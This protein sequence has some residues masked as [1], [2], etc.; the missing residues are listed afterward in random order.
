MNNNN[1]SSKRPNSRKIVETTSN[2]LKNNLELFEILND[3]NG[4]AIGYTCTPCNNKKFNSEPSL[5]D[6]INSH[7]SCHYKVWHSFSCNSFIS[8]F[9]SSL[10]LMV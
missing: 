8:F 4:K 2:I 6:H 1:N 10:Y 5:R 3:E 9:I 7:I